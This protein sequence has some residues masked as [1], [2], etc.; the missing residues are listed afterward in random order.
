MFIFVMLQA[1]LFAQ[2]NSPYSFYGIG[3]RGSLGNPVFSG[4]GNNSVSFIQPTIFNSANPASYSFLRKQYPIFSLG[5]SSRLSTYSANGSS[6]FKGYSGI[7]ELGFGLSFAKYFGL[8]FGLTPFTRKGY[9]FSQVQAFQSDSLRYDYIG[10]GSTN[11]AYLG[12]SAKILDLTIV[13]KSDQTRDPITIDWAVGSNLGFVFGRLNNERRSYLVSSTSSA[14]GIDYKSINIKSAH[15]EFGTAFKL[16]LR[17]KSKLVLAGT[18]E[19]KQN[20]KGTYSEQLFFSV[21]D[22][23]NP[24]TYSL[25]NDKGTLASSITIA[26]SY[27]VGANYARI[28]ESTLKN[29]R[30]RSSELTLYL[31]YSNT[32]WTKYSARYGDSTSNYNFKSS[33]GFNV[34]FQYTPE[35]IFEQAA[36]P[37]FFSRLSYRIGYY[38]NTLPYSYNNIQLN[39]FGTTFGLGIPILIDKRLES[40]I[41]LGLTYGQR[42]TK[43]PGSLNETFYGI[44]IG[45]MIA[46]SNADRWFTKQRID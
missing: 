14:G 24:N 10:S 37:N 29:G 11:K 7:S 38:Q 17:D 41:Q 40:S 42:G 3:E 2:N 21:S 5:V 33:S 36:I 43:E 1:G 34:G 45:F 13:D 32:N 6:E 35:T 19:P 9:S 22:V 25:I 20:L 39:E 46:P 12:F 15:F 4:L 44:N 27:T 16:Q 31:S 8:G 30:I 18:F 26:P 28:F 23:S